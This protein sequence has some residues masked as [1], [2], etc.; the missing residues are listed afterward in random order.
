M[1]FRIQTK[2]DEDKG[3][4]LQNG[5]NFLGGLGMLLCGI[6]TTKKGKSNDQRKPFG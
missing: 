2:V 4:P 5:V 1:N 6:L 3:S